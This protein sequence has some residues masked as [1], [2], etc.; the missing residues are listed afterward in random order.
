MQFKS[1][2]FAVMCM[3]SAT[4]AKGWNSYLNFITNDAIANWTKEH[5]AEWHGHPPLQAYPHFLAFILVIL[6]AAVVAAGI[7]YSVKVTSAIAVINISIL[8]FLA[9]LGYIHANIDNWTPQQNGGF[10]PYGVN[11]VI[12]GVM[13]YFWA[14]AGFECI[15]NAVEKSKS[16]SYSVPRATVIAL[17]VVTVVY[18]MMAAVMTLIIPYVYIDPVVP[19]PSIF[20][21]DGIAWAGIISAVAPLFGLT[22][23]GINGVFGASQVAYGMSRDGLLPAIFSRINS[24]TKTPLINIIMMGLFIGMLAMLIALDTVIEAGLVLVL[25]IFVSVCVS[26]IILRYKPMNITSSST[27]ELKDMKEE[28]KTY[29]IP[30]SRHPLLAKMAKSLPDYWIG[31]QIVCSIVNM[32]F[33]SAIIRFAGESLSA[34]VWWPW[35]LLAVLCV[36]NIIVMLSLM[37]FEQNKH[38]TAFEVRYDYPVDS[39]VIVRNLENNTKLHKCSLHYSMWIAYNET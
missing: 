34:G 21:Q 10:F 13:E 11:G 22:T 37:L 35:L 27:Y 32:A 33:I 4:S 20:S 16:P 30:K 7:Q 28:E 5:I 14:F 39:C 2:L 18:L 12:A 1:L 29:L 24:F 26:V 8:L 31:P 9:I 38:I 19:L 6:M 36:A 23:G 25:L 17:I 3:A 15:S